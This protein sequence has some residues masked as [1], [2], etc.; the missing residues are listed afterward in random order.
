MSVLTSLFTGPRL[1]QPQPLTPPSRGDAAIEDARRRELAAEA[2]TRG[3]GANYLT[4]GA[5]LGAAPVSQ[6]YLLGQ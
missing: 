5:S 6:R 2:K 3:P 4:G 1:P